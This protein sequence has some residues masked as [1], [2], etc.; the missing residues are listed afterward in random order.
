MIPLGAAA[1]RGVDDLMSSGTGCSFMA[2][3]IDA[4]N[5]PL[6]GMSAELSPVEARFDELERGVDRVA[7]ICD[8]PDLDGRPRSL[9]AEST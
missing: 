8:D 5:C 9:Y 7:G 3:T 4:T 1:A 2:S 6:I